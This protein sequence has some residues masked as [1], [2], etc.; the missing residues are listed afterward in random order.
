MAKTWFITGAN[1]GLGL[2]IAKCALHAGHNV[3]AAGRSRPA[4]EAAL[5][6]AGGQLLPIELD[7]PRSGAG[8]GRR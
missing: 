3:V 1:R 8:P 7:V 6:P 5:G 4:V 2:E